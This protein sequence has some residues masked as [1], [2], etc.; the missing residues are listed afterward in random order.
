[1]YSKAIELNPSESI[2]YSNRAKAFKKLNKLNEVLFFDLRIYFTK[3]KKDCIE[4]I[5][6]DNNNF[7]AYLLYG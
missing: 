1:M 3:A 2:Y 4:A 7:K 5:E 6:L